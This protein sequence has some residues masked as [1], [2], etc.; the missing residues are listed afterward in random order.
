MAEPQNFQSAKCLT[1]RDDLLK[2]RLDSLVTKR[3]INL[4]AKEELLKYT[5]FKMR[6]G[7]IF[8]LLQLLT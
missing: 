2:S 7:Q 8:S 6:A 1:F 3:C 4:V 5:N